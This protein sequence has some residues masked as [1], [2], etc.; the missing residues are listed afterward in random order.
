MFINLFKAAITKLTR[1][2][3]TLLAVL[4]SFIL[5]IFLRFIFPFVSDFFFSGTGFQLRNYY[6]IIAITLLSIIPMF[7][8]MASAFKP[9]VPNESKRTFI[10][11]KMKV[12]AVLSFVLVLLSVLLTDPVPDEG[13]LRTIFISFLL[14][15]QSVFV[16]LLISGFARSRG[17][18]RTLSVLYGIFLAAVPAGLILHHP[19]NYFA[20]FSPLYWISW[21]WGISQ[22]VESLMYGA[23]S[24]IITSGCIV[25]FYRQYFKKHTI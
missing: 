3:A 10:F 14:S 6:T 2:P 12:P 16:F 23:I 5:I 20:F 25:I 7:F 11:T 9:E 18:A 15:A 21:A 17:E 22:P 13:W 1:D 19:W 24:M 4:A 8:G